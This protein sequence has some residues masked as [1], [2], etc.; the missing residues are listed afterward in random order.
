[1][2]TGSNIEGREVVVELLLSARPGPSCVVVEV[3]GDLDFASTPQLRELLQTVA[4][5]GD[6]QIVIDLAKVGFMDS[7]ALGM[8]V[9]MFKQLREVGGDLRLAA[10]Q[11]SP[12]LVLTLTSIDQAIDVYET[13][14]EA[15]TGVRSSKP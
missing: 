5:A 6:R 2:T 4:D 12:R 1:M 15:L 3:T 9:V 7:T 13:L 14:G 8:L 10:P 11:R